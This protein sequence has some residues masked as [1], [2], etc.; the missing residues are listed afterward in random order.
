V[1][2]PRVRASACFTSCASFSAKAACTCTNT[3]RTGP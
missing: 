2:L 3:Q 1:L